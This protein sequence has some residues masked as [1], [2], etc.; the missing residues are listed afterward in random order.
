[1]S[2]ERKKILDMVASGQISPE[3]G[4]ALLESVQIDFGGKQ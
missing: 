1:M 4:T 2:E 3:Q